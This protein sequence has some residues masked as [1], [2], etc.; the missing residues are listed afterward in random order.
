MGAGCSNSG[1]MA[2]GLEQMYE[3]LQKDPKCKSLMKVA[4][5]KE[6]VEKYK[7]VKTSLGAKLED[8]IKS[9]VENLDSGCGI[10]AADPE[11]YEVFRDV[12]DRIIIDY[13]KC[14]GEPSHPEPNF[15][16]VDNLGWGDLDPD[17]NLVLSTRI[18][19]GRNIANKTF[20]PLI[21]KE[22][23]YEIESKTKEV[24]G[25]LGGEYAGS[26]HSLEGM[27]EDV[28]KQLVNDHFLFKNDDRFLESA[29]G[30]RDWP[31]GRG[32]FYNENKTFLVWSNEEDALRIISMQEGG[33]V[34]Q[35]YKRLVHAANALE[36]AMPFAKNPRLGYLTFCPTNLGTGLRASVHMKLPN[37]SALP[38]FKEICNKMHL[39]PRGIHGEHTESEGGVYDI[40]NKRR[41]GLTE[42]QAVTEMVRGV[43]ILG[44]LEKS[45]AATKK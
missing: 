23:R 28:R 9:G 44:L 10:Y 31:L 8:C 16:D 29:G 41:L 12:F 34:E 43:Q 6:A 45:L 14:T 5:T 33:D 26:Y 42:Y 30:Y 13:H 37:V 3:V 2:E 11:S 36:K 39:Q 22:D 15:G 17:K 21:S 18:R 27:S 4:L 40:S 24:L 35:V 19:V 32:I 38:D 20:P 7:D 1:K 25:N